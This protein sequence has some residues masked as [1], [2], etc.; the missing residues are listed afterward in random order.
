MVEASS[1]F[2]DRLQQYFL[3]I[4]RGQ[5]GTF[6]FSDCGCMKLESSRTI[7]PFIKASVNEGLQ[8]R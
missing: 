7:S 5:I 6:R 1:F 3:L 8:Q 2:V 4:F